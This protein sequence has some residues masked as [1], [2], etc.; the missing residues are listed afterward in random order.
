[1]SIFELLFFVFVAFA[2]PISIDRMIRNKST[3][4]K[5]LAYS[6]IIVLG[7][8]FGIVHK[9]IYDLDWVLAIYILDLMLVAADIAVFIYIKNKYEKVAANAV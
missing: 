2:W 3:K 6:F 7:Y 8:A 9:C 4:G 1:M 5:A